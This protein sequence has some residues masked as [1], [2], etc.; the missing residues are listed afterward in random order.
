MKGTPTNI[1]EILARVHGDTQERLA[2]VLATVG[3]AVARV[4]GWREVRGAVYKPE[5]TGLVEGQYPCNQ[6]TKLGY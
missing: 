2:E 6:Q 1:I 4:P 5:T 3:P